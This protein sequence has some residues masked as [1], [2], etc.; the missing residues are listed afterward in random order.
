MIA[1]G[2]GQIV[3]QEFDSLFKDMEKAVA[4]VCPH[5]MADR[6]DDLI[7]NAAIRLMEILRKEVRGKFPSS[8]Y[9]RVA[10]SVLVDEIRKQERKKETPLEN[11]NG[12]ERGWTTDSPNPEEKAAGRELGRS[13][14]ECL[15]KLNEPR[16]MAVALKLQ[17]HTIPEAARILSWSEKRTNNL[18]YRGLKDLRDCL[19]SKGL[20]P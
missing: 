2:K 8:Y 12:T 5:W 13:I 17:G 14:G 9:R 10:Y 20:K 19:A 1:K 16:R 18:V 7:Q 3:D 15:A 11:D 6:R 4:S